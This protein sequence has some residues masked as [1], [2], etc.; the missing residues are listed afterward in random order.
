[1]LVLTLAAVFVVLGSGISLA[2]KSTPAAAWSVTDC[3]GCHEKALGTSFQNTKHAKL[4]QSC[5]QCHVNV[6]EHAKA[7]LNGEKNA[8]S[9]ALKNLTAAQVNDKCLS[10]HEKA[11]QSN[12]LSSMHARRNVA[13]TSCHSAHSAKSV[14]AQLKTKM[15]SDTCYT[16]HKSERAKAMR[17]SH[18]PVREGKMG[19]SSCH[20]PH[21]GS[22]PKMIKADSINELCYK[23]HAEKRGPF[24]FEHAPVREDCAT[25]H[26]PHGSNHKRMLTQKLPTLCYNCHLSGSGHFGSGDN[27]NTEKGAKVAPAGAATGYPTAG[28]RFVERS[29]RNCH[30]QIHGSNHPSGVAFI[31]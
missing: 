6:A 1:M 8:P 13:C 15:D 9:P 19:C 30:V 28:S 23:C 27:L 20:N 2:Q 18:H 7:Q 24:A 12:Y 21:D 11:K 14:K 17:T 25:C 3:Q 22:Q 5:V 10:C 29:C 31:R 4:D 26:D 16:C